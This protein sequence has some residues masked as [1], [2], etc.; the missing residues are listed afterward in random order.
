RSR[1]GGKGR[2]ATKRRSLAANR[3][4]SSISC[5]AT[6]AP[7]LPRS[8]TQPGGSRTRFAAPS[9]ARSRGSLDW[10]SNPRTAAAAES[11][12]FARMPDPSMETLE[13]WL[14]AIPKLPDSKLADQWAA[15]F[16]RPPP[17]GISQRLLELAA[18]YQAQA[19]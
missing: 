3:R 17:R 8:R 2:A 13:Q 11:I 10:L 15:L 9:A 18:A 4:S 1:N 19:N 6:G 5:A 7:P 16:G 14:R 12:G